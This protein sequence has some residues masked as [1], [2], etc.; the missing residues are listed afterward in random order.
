MISYLRQVAIC[1]LV[2]EAVK[3][4]LTHGNLAGRLKITTIPSTDNILRAASLHPDIDTE[5][6]LKELVTEYILKGL[7]LTP[8][9]REQLRANI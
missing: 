7:R 2:Q 3:Q 1:A 9:E 8:I 4:G 5:E 6:G